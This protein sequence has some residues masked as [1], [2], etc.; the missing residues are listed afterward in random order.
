M[1]NSEKTVLYGVMAFIAYELYQ[2]KKCACG[3]AGG[4][5]GAGGSGSGSGSAS[6]GVCVAPASPLGPGTTMLAPGWVQQLSQVQGQDYFTP[7]CGFW[8]RCS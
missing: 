2:Q 1:T 5:A 4:A 3:A 6:A 8:G 7:R